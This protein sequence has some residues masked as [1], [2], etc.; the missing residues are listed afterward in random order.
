MTCT[1]SA[2][3]T[4]FST[5]AF[6]ISVAFAPSASAQWADFRYQNRTAITV[7]NPS[8]HA[9]ASGDIVTAT[10]PVGTLS[11]VRSDGADVA[12]Y[13]GSTAVPVKVLSMGGSLKALLQ[14][15]SPLAAILPYTIT[16]NL[17]AGKTSYAA[18]PAGTRLDFADNDDD[19]Y[20]TVTLPF[21]FPFKP[22]QA[23]NKLTINLDGFVTPGPTDAGRPDSVA[24][25]LTKYVIMPYASDYQIT[26]APAT[27]VYVDLS[28]PAQATIRWEV[29]PSGQTTLVA[30]F[31]LI[32]KPNGDIRFV[33][34]T[35]CA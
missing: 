7:A 9:F 30:R 28:N 17:S 20:R 4:V 22:G 21:N 16:E 34:G 18:L 33:Y 11:G 15:P 8:A 2:A 32:L 6:I 23:S 1:K 24:A 14:L 26:S 27:G 12:L 13:Q 35:P 3:R 25:A 5:L 31:A 10:L 19:A 29:C